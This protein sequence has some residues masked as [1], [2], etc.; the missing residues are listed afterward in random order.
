M[1]TTA[2]LRRQAINQDFSGA[3]SGGVSSERRLSSFEYD[4]LKSYVYA[5]HSGRCDSRELEITRCV[6]HSSLSHRPQKPSI[7]D[8]GA[9]SFAVIGDGV[10]EATVLWKSHPYEVTISKETQYDGTRN[11]TIYCLGLSAEASS[12]RQL[13]ECL[14]KESVANSFY[15]NQILRVGW[16]AMAERPLTVKPIKVVGQP[17]GKIILKEDV[18]ESVEFMIQ[19]ILAYPML[20]K[21]L[22]YL[23]EGGPGTGKTE[24]IRS[25]IDACNGFGTFLLVEGSVDLVELFDFAS[26]FEP[27][28]ICLDD[29][30]L[31]FGNRHETANR[32]SLGEFLTLLDG[33]A[34]CNVF[35]L[36]TVNERKYLDEAASR[37]CRWD[38]ILNIKAP[39]SPLYLK[40]IKERCTNDRVVELFTTQVIESMESRDVT[41]AFIVNLVKHLEITH[42][43]SPEKLNEQ[44]V[45]TT[46]GRMHKGFYEDSKGSA[47]PVG[48]EAN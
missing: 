25:I 9:S 5:V 11:H 24:T 41:G 17:L 26:L 16:N 35:V 28:I 8:V 32:E 43:L 42:A 15:R 37:P 39:M 33:V 3:Q 4:F 12:A 20:R 40:L 6:A 38:L 1:K 29:L 23:L 22:R 45:L 47:T 7:I 31:S 18:R 34:K 27:C 19:T 30:D 10:L 44:Y 13:L 14:L 48:F 46:V 36:G 21:S 2:Q